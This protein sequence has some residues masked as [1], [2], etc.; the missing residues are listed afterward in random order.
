M[1]IRST[2]FAGFGAIS[3]AFVSQSASFLVYR[4]MS[5][6]G[7]DRWACVTRWSVSIALGL[8]LTLALSGYLNFVSKTDANILN[9]FG[10][11]HGPAN[12]ARAFLA[13]TMVSERERERGRGQHIASH[14]K[15]AE[16]MVFLSATD[17]RLAFFFTTGLCVF[18]MSRQQQ[19]G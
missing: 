16:W 3:F 10:T 17:D 15:Y 14:Q 6:G 1:F 5:K 8:G 4:S 18:W 13:L 2:V 19:L 11:R 12:I 9:N 7:V